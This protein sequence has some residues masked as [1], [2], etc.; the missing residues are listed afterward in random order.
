LALR[1]GLIAQGKTMWRQGAI[2]AARPLLEEALRRAITSGDIVQTT[3]AWG[4]LGLCLC[5]AG[6]YE[7]AAKQLA[8]AESHMRQRKVRTCTIVPIFLGLAQVAVARLEANGQRGDARIALK[9]CRD[10]VSI[11]RRFYFGL[12]RALRLMG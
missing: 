12:A 2:E 1:T 11:G 10:A 9:R 8:Q 7:G 5:E 6:D 3:E 4:E